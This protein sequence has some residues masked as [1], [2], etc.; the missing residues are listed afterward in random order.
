MLRKIHDEIMAPIEGWGC[1]S[2]MECLPRVFAPG[3]A[4]D[5]NSPIF[6]SCVAGITYVN[7]YAWLVY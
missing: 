7:H 5:Y 4:L 3:L 2:V 1:H 6:A